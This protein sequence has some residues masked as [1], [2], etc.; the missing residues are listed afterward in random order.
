[1]VSDD[2]FD[3]MMENTMYNEYQ[4]V[5]ES[6]I[7]FQGVIVDVAAAG[8]MGSKVDEVMDASQQ[9]MAV[10]TGTSWGGIPTLILG[11]AG[12]V[13]WHRR[14]TASTGRSVGD[15]AFALDGWLRFH[16]NRDDMDAASL[17]QVADV[18]ERLK[19]LHGVLVEG[20]RAADL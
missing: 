19:S 11:L 17:A 18:V 8:E 6:L 5:V 12:M 9:A 10:I 1:M 3:E 14:Q 2:G 16:A 4:A 15:V 13:A 20:A 7:D